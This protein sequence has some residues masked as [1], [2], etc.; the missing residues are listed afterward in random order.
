[1]SWV[2]VQPM[3]FTVGELSEGYQG[4]HN[5]VALIGQAV[6]LVIGKLHHMAKPIPGYGTGTA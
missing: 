6:K 3:G 5:E 2:N 4:N 1:M